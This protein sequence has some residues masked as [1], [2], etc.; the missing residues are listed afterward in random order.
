HVVLISAGDQC[1]IGNIWL[2]SRRRL[3]ACRDCSSNHN[4]TGEDY[5]CFHD[6]DLSGS[7]TWR[8]PKTRPCRRDYFGLSAAGQWS[9]P[10]PA[11]AEENCADRFSELMTPGCVENAQQEFFYAELFLRCSGRSNWNS[12]PFLAVGR[13]S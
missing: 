9:L 11:T 8:K 12:R 1:F 3:R 5:C 13:G 4:C 2:I 10:S 6:V 7:E